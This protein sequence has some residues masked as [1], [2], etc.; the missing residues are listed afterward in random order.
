MKLNLRGCKRISDSGLGFLSDHCSAL[1]WID[2]SLSS[3]RVTEDGISSLAEGII[4]IRYLTHP[5]TT[6][7]V[8]YG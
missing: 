5:F 1:Q 7:F 8:V 4:H 3:R 6:H 2:L